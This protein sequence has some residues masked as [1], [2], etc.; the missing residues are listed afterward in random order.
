MGYR[1][2]IERH[3]ASFLSA[4]VQIWPNTARIIQ[5]HI[6]N[7]HNAEAIFQRW[8][9]SE[10]TD[11]IQQMSNEGIHFTT[12]WE[13][14]MIRQN[15][16]MLEWICPTQ[17]SLTGLEG[18]INAVAATGKAAWIWAELRKRDAARLLGFIGK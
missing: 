12:E 18:R 14:G 4:S 15:G 1:S 17:H 7:E 2:A 13:V 11:A 16:D 9:K 3:K 8:G 5:T 6:G 10:A